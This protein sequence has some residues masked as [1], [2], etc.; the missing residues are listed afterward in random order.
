MGTHDHSAA[1]QAGPAEVRTDDDHWRISTQ[2]A[3]CHANIELRDTD[4]PM[5]WFH[6]D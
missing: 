2:C 4:G 6:L 5:R 3:I 1:P